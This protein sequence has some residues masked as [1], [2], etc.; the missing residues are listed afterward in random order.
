MGF[1]FRR[2]APVFQL[3]PFFRTHSPLLDQG[4]F[5][6]LMNRISI[7]LY[8]ENLALSKNALL[9]DHIMNPNIK[10]ILSRD[11]ILTVLCDGTFIYKHTCIA[12]RWW[13]ASL[14]RTIHSGWVYMQQPIQIVN[15]IFQKR[16]F[17]NMVKST[18]ICY[19]WCLFKPFKI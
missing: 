5:N 6:L 11:T 14:F 8:Q 16:N 18:C 4:N 3:Y 13:H 19:Y 10:L 9:E 12:K 17:V 2:Y 1:F 15:Q 7:K